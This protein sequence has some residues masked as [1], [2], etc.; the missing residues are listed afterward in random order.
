MGLTH[1]EQ[2][3]SRGFVAGV[4]RGARSF[5]INKDGFLTGVVYHQVWTPGENIAVCRNT[6]TQYISYY[7]AASVL[8]QPVALPDGHGMDACRHGFYAYAEN[9]NDYHAEGYV[10]GVIEGYG[11][12]VMLGT[13]GFRADKAR[14]VALC[15]SE[16]RLTERDRVALVSV[17]YPDIPMFN[18]FDQMVAEYP[19]DAGEDN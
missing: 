12:E 9:S 17:N 18:T 1:A 14:I 16:V 6:P 3:D 4:F 19:P 13:R 5:R 7:A 10:S 11:K 15:V 2:F 8:D